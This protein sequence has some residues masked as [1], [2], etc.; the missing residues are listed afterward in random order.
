[1]AI[2]ARSFVNHKREHRQKVAGKRLKMWKNGR[3]GG[4]KLV[5]GDSREPTGHQNAHGREGVLPRRSDYQVIT[6][7]R[8]GGLLTS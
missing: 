3:I 1:M 5:A 8:E 7:K 4:I 6:A 2:D